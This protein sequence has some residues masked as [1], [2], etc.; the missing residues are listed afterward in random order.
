MSSTSPTR[1]SP[2]QAQETYGAAGSS[3]PGR[4][5]ETRELPSSNGQNRMSPR[6]GVARFRWQLA[7]TS[8]TN[9]TETTAPRN[10]TDTQEHRVNGSESTAEI[11]SPQPMYGVSASDYPVVAG[12][13]AQD[14]LTQTAGAFDSQSTVMH[15]L[16][17]P[18]LFR[19]LL[20]SARSE[21]ANLDF[22]MPSN[23]PVGTAP[24][25]PALRAMGPESMIWDD[26]YRLRSVFSAPAHNAVNGNHTPLRESLNNLLQQ[27]H[28]AFFRHFPDP[29]FPALAHDPNAPIESM[30]ISFRNPQGGMV[31][32]RFGDLNSDV[33]MQAERPYLHIESQ[34]IRIEQQNSRVPPQQGRALVLRTIQW[35]AE[36]L[37]PVDMDVEVVINQGDQRIRQN[38]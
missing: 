23:T 15:S 24:R 30:E 2:V 5:E 7:R 10:F 4:T 11:H 17:S 27:F 8:D 1:P 31:S 26:Q 9:N 28:H 35:M 6:A 36:D 34:D 21:L 25:G 13:P 29:D 22:L 3:E 38:W 20:A 37:V 32:F 14:G 16:I 19:S 33:D 12:P 18:D